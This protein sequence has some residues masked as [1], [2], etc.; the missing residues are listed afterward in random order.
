VSNPPPAHPHLPRDRAAR[1][2]ILVSIARSERTISE[3]YSRSL[4]VCASTRAR[5]LAMLSL[6]ARAVAEHGAGA[7]RASGHPRPWGWSGPCRRHAGPRSPSPASTATIAATTGKPSGPS[8]RRS[9]RRRRGVRPRRGPG[10]WRLEEAV[11]DLVGGDRLDHVGELERRHR[12]LK[13]RHHLVAGVPW[14]EEALRPREI[15][16]VLHARPWRN[17]LETRRAPSLAFA[18]LASI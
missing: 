10:R 1:L 4:L 16:D 17:S 15:G 3:L 6:F 13:L 14:L 8:S 11:C 5:L 12:P 9:W 18:R 2:P 7:L